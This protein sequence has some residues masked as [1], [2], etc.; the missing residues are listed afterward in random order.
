MYLLCQDFGG[1]RYMISFRG[2]QRQFE[3]AP[4]PTEYVYCVSCGAR[5]K[6]PY[7]TTAYKV[8]LRRGRPETDVYQLPNCSNCW[9]P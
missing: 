8:P 3:P 1:L 9:R 6:G 7:R 2:R 4:Y 5:I